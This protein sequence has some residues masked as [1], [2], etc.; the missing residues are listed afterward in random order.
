MRGRACSISAVLSISKP[1]RNRQSTRIFLAWRAFNKRMKHSRGDVGIW[2]ETYLVRAGEYE[3]AYSGIP[4][5]GLGR[6]ADLV[7]AEG[8]RSDARGRFKR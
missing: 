6:V 2:H 7:P 1:I 8:A 3:N 5:H 4:P